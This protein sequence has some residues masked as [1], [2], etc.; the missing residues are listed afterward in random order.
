[1]RMPT[2]LIAGEPVRES[3][4]HQLVDHMRSYALKG[5]VRARVARRSGGTTISVPSPPLPRVSLARTLFGNLADYSDS[6]VLFK[7]GIQHACACIGSNIYV[8]RGRV[9]WSNLPIVE[10]VHNDDHDTAFEDANYFY[11][12]CEPWTINEPRFVYAHINV[13]GSPAAHIRL[14]ESADEPVDDPLAELIRWPLATVTFLSATAM[15]VIE[16]W[17]VGHI[18]ITGV[19]GRP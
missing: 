8:R 12:V 2:P 10:S 7:G 1:M 14:S 11:I 9:T 19:G 4:S 16:P 6:E 15:A 3:W 17:H 18:K 13:G 5:G